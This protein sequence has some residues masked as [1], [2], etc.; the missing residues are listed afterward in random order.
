MI[1]VGI[2]IGTTSVKVTLLSRRQ[3]GDLQVLCSAALNHNADRP[4]R[5]EKFAEQ[6]PSAICRSLENCI[7][8]IALKVGEEVIQQTEIISICGQ[9]HGCMLWNSNVP[10]NGFFSH[11]QLITWRDQ[12]C[13]DEFLKSLPDPENCVPTS[14]GFGCAT[15]FW[16]QKHQSHILDVYNSA[17]T[18]MDYV[19]ANLCQLEK[20]VMS[21][22]NAMSWGFYNFCTEEWNVRIL[23]ESMF[24][25]G[26]LPKIGH[27]GDHVGKLK[28]E[29]C[30]FKEGTKVLIGCG[31]MQCSVLSC[32]PNANVAIFNLGTSAQLSVLS[33][34]EEGKKFYKNDHTNYV[35]AKICVPYFYNKCLWTSASLN[36]GAVFEVFVK[37]LYEWTKHFSSSVTKEDIYSMIQ[38]VTY[39]DMGSSTAMKITPTLYG[40]RHAPLSKAS[41]NC[42]SEADCK[43]STI[44]AEL[45]TGIIANV[46]QMYQMGEATHVF[47]NVQQVWGCGTPFQKNRLFRSALERISGL[48]CVFDKSTDAAFGAAILAARQE[49]YS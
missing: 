46:F 24:P 1:V 8:D 4:L 10:K 11:S 20:P 48:P 42:I 41:V 23:Q 3:G 40:E 30:G 36:G 35:K 9:M 18:I 33:E 17:G 19:V 38:E 32:D 45:A 44:A 13:D 25:V 15:L 7:K 49:K 28:F 31:D 34:L 5:D 16:L 26:V 37:E 39:K 14:T 6:D 47:H 27:P 12:R 29:W 21:T 43:I 2:D 22:Q